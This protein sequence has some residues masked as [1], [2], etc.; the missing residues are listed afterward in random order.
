MADNITSLSALSGETNA[1]IIYV[2]GATAF[3][4]TGGADKALFGINRDANLAPGATRLFFTQR[5]LI[6]NPVDSGADNTYEVEVTA[7]VGGTS[8]TTLY[9]LKIVD[10]DFRADNSTSG[11]LPADGSAVAGRINLASDRDWFRFE[12]NGSPYLLSIRGVGAYELFNQDGKS[13]GL[14]S[15][16]SSS[17]FQ[18]LNLPA[19]TYFLSVGGPVYNA[20]TP[21]DYLVSLSPSSPG[22]VVAT[23]GDDTR[24]GTGLADFIA[25][26]G[27]SDV[28]NGLGGNDILD[29]GDGD[30][31]ISG[32]D[33]NDLLFGRGGTNTLDGGAGYDVAA[34]AETL[35]SYTVAIT[36][37]GWEVRGRDSIDK[38]TGIEAI[39]FADRRAAPIE[40]YLSVPTQV[41]TPIQNMLRG[42]ATSTAN[43]PV[44][45]QLTTSFAQGTLDA[46]GIV[47]K[48]IKI[49]DA[50]TTVATLSYQFFTGKIP[51]LGGIDYLVS[52][53]GPNPNNLNSAYYQ[54]FN[55]ENRYINFA[56]NLG[57]DGEGKVAF[58]AKY[59]TLSLF[60]ATREAYKTIFGGTP[61]DEK[62]HA[63]IDSRV[64][65]FASYGGDGAGGIGTKAAMVGW[66]LAEAAKADV[67][68]YAR[69][70]DAFL[71]DLADGATFAIDLIGVYS[72]PEFS[73]G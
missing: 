42:S 44:A 54:S 6:S 10:D 69:S 30:D 64:D 72:R 60:E 48:I 57:R 68:M 8:Q 33:G 70:S 66:L 40:Q 55:L 62:V 23:N 3:A 14:L 73:F 53:S 13:V 36:A 63:L 5:P 52:G 41:A 56:V 17:T 9:R 59:G 29:G 20:V 58:A 26:N 35:S 4:I 43:L 16:S 31:V 11:V 24:T 7:T 50:T 19:G 47:Q 51:S 38:V 71:N 15:S 65:Y 49:S 32:G 39:E 22:M 12:S 34:Y 25:G 21:G 61:N 46:A 1:T 27:G 18:F 37:T 28:L 2:P 45:V 67:G